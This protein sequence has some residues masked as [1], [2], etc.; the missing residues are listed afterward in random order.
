MHSRRLL[1]VIFTVAVAMLSATF[2]TAFGETAG[3]AAAPNYGGDLVIARLGDMKGLDP[4]PTYEPE[5]LITLLAIMETPLA[6]GGDGK[7]A[8]QLA[9]S[10]TLGGDGLTWTMK[11]REGVQFSNGAPLTSADVKFSIDRARLSSEGFSYLLAPIAVVNVVDD[12]TLQIVTSKPTAYLPSLMTLWIIGVVPADYGGKTRKEFFEAPIGT[13]PFTF[14]AW[15]PGKSVTLLRNKNYWQKGK[16]YL[17]SVTWTQ[18]PDDNSR[19]VQIQGGKAQIAAALPFSAADQVDA[20]G[21]VSVKEFNS[22]IVW[23]LIFNQSKPVFQDAHVRRAIAMALDKKSMLQA[24]N[25]GRGSAACSILPPSMPYHSDTVPCLAFDVEAAKAE[26][27]ASSVPNGFSTSLLIG[28]TDTAAGT[29]AEIAVAN[30]AQIGINLTIDKVD[31][32]QLYDIQS[33]GGYDMIYQWWASDIVDPNEQLTFMLDPGIGGTQSY[34][35]FYNN[36]EIVDLLAKGRSEFSDEARSKLYAKVQDLQAADVPHVPILYSPGM[37]AVSD[38][39]HGF[40]VL[41][42]GTYFLQNIWLEK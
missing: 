14:S 1:G 19:V 27:A 37:F 31:P 36:A 20:I 16:P 5:T 39:V 12:L 35:S 7:I 3:S 17:D 13:G 40:D 41:R 2:G 9:T 10:L 29:F 11:L 15:T 8:P 32:A 30:L 34:W 23:F 6:N 4:L 25:F 38:K 21:G 18:V 28:G 26:M 24:V 22:S 33:Q 42:T